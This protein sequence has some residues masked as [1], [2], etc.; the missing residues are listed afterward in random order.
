MVHAA[1]FFHLF[2]WDD[3]VRVGERIVRFFKPGAKA[4]LVLGRQVGSP[5]PPSL[6]EYR[7]S[8]ETRYHHSPESLQLLWDEIGARTATKWKA[9][10]NAARVR[11]GRPPEG[12]SSALPCTGLSSTRPLFPGEHGCR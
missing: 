11:P 2:G 10:G 6:E 9:H 8:G 1:S 12:S 4:P 7:A 5:N 3:Q